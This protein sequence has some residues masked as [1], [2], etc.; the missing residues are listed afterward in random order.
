MA[1]QV[2]IECLV[3]DAHR[4]TSQNTWGAVSLERDFKMLISEVL[5]HPSQI[6]VYPGQLSPQSRLSRRDVQ[7]RR[8]LLSR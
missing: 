7:S 1:M 5:D 8:L 6:K 2:G 4:S 3:S